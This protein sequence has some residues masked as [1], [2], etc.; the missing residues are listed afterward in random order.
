MDLTTDLGWGG[1]G[2]GVFCGFNLA[3][4]LWSLSAT[5]VSGRGTE[6]VDI[7]TPIVQVHTNPAP[8]QGNYPIII[9]RRDSHSRYLFTLSQL[10]E[11][12]R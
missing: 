3:T 11:T 2:W 9:N 7:H 1:R 12:T 4:H 10:A 5:R 8:T 6:S